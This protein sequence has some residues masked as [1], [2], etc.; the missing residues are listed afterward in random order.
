VSI[1]PMIYLPYL[2]G[3]LLTFGTKFIRR[4]ITHISEAFRLTL[5]APAIVLNATGISAK[6]LGGVEDT[7]VYPTRGQLVLVSNEC[8]RMYA[9]SMSKAELGNN[10]TY[11]IPRAFGGGTVLGGCR[12]DGN[13]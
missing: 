12:Q 7:D 9:R 2:Q 5:P 11:I 10:W 3:Q 6:I 1:N 4:H 8:P 13:W